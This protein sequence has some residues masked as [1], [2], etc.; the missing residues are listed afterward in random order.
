MAGHLLLLLVFVLLRG[1]QVFG[2]FHDLIFAILLKLQTHLS[3]VG[4]DTLRFS[5]PMF[6]YCYYFG[7]NIYRRI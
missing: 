3:C 5:L 4:K 2:Q 1:L 6:L 7:L